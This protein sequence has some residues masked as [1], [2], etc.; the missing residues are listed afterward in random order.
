MKKL[1]FLFL[2]L[3]LG[4]AQV[5]ASDFVGEVRNAKEP[6]EIA[7][8]N[9]AVVLEM[10]EGDD[11]PCIGIR[12]SDSKIN[13][14]LGTYL[15]IKQRGDA[16]LIEG[17]KYATIN[18]G[19]EAYLKDLFYRFYDNKKYGRTVWSAFVKEGGLR[20][21]MRIADEFID[22]EFLHSPLNEIY[23]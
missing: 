20:S 6:R 9:G 17:R 3:L 12:L 2:A 13:M 19:I 5:K 4:M 21:F 1:A 22:D 14:G 15:E 11:F 23:G 8:L 16:Y 18:A 7:I 10:T